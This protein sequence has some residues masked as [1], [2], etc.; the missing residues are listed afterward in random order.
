MKLAEI[1]TSARTK[2][3]LSMSDVARTSAKFSKQDHR[4]RITQG[5]ISRLESGKETNQSLKK[6]ETLCQIYRIEPD[7][8]FIKRRRH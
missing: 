4:C 6:L 5:Y 1:L 8:L 3:G 2:N 7:T